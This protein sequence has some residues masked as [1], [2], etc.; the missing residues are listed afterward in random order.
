MEKDEI[1][2]WLQGDNVHTANWETAC[3]EDGG[4]SPLTMEAGK[5]VDCCSLFPGNTGEQADAEQAYIQ[6]EWTGN[7]LGWAT[8]E[9][10]AS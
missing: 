6:S 4:C 10:L 8:G 5:V 2:G 3:F 7:Y 9:S 1:Q